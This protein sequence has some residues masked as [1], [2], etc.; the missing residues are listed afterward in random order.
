MQVR[1]CT[2]GRV[3]EELMLQFEA[4]QSWIHSHIRQN[5]VRFLSVSLWRTVPFVS[6]PKIVDTFASSADIQ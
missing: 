1:A 4:F 6:S 3:I 5:Q 2:L